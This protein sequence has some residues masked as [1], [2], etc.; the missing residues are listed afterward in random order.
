MLNIFG[1]TFIHRCTN[2]LSVTKQ[3]CDAFLI[4]SL[5]TCCSQ[6]FFKDLSQS[7][8]ISSKRE[9]CHFKEFYALFQTLI[10]KSEKQ[11]STSFSAK[12]EY[13]DFWGTAGNHFSF[14][15]IINCN[16]KNT[17]GGFSFFFWVR[18]LIFWLLQKNLNFCHHCTPFL[19]TRKAPVHETQW[20]EQ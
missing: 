11:S 10:Y 1:I 6:K 9:K 5:T 2:L 18:K 15:S 8:K 19:D 7:P 13:F 20:S 3:F 17:G 4:W 12:L 14:F 16:R